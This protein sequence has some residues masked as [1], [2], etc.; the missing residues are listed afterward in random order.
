MDCLKSGAMA[1]EGNGFQAILQNS[2]FKLLHTLL[3]LLSTGMEQI[4]V[5]T[6]KVRTQHNAQL[7]RF[8]RKPLSNT[9]VKESSNAIQEYCVGDPWK[10]GATLPVADVG[11]NLAAVSWTQKGKPHLRIYYQTEDLSVQEHCYDNGWSKGKFDHCIAFM[12]AY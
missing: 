10:K 8:E 7:T 12:V 9:W 2:R 3:L 4:F 6:A 11:S 1:V 5:C